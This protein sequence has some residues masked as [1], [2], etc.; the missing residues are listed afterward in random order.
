MNRAT[1]TVIMVIAAAVLVGAGFLVGTR[2]G[3]AQGNGPAGAAT[4]NAPPSGA[5]RVRGGGAVQPV[6]GHVLAV[7]DGSITVQVDRPGD[8]A[9]S[10]VALVGST[11]RVVRLTETDLK[12]GDIKVGDQVTVIGSTDSTSGAVAANAVI[13]GSGALLFFGQGGGAGAG[14]GQRSGSPRPTATP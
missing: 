1:Q 2:V 7:G 5:T 9:R 14:G 6:S 8:Q 13:V 12:P 4:K 11:A 3:N 10:V